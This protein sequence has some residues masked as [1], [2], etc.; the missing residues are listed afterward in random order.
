MLGSKSEAGEFFFYYDTNM[1]E[2]SPFEQILRVRMIST[3]GRF[4]RI[5]GVGMISPH[6]P[7][8][9]FATKTTTTVLREKGKNMFFLGI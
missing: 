6:S 1:A 7:R 8:G 4:S 9:G 3:P 5:P 2:I